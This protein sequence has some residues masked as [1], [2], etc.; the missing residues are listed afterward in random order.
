MKKFYCY[1]KKGEPVVLETKPEY[2]ENKAHK[3]VVTAPDLRVAERVY[4]ADLRVKILR[5]S[6]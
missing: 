1:I 5:N 2:F 6:A 3:H 4:A